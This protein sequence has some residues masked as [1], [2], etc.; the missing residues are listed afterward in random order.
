MDRAVSRGWC[1]YILSNN[2]HTLYVGSTDD[3]LHRIA[4]HTLKIRSKA[5]TARYTF[6]RCV[7]FEFA[8]DEKTARSREKQIKGWTRAKKIAL[9]QEKNPNGI[10]VTP[11]LDTVLRF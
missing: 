5:F 4:E 6:D 9:I 10:D 8:P 1:V 2:A 11:R 3:L 7:F